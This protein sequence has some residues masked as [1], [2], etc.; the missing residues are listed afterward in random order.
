MKFDELLGVYVQM[1]FFRQNDLFFSY[2]SDSGLYFT[3]MHI[4][5]LGYIHREC[6][7]KLEKLCVR[8]K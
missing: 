6:D 8:N 7:S 3:W 2:G 5:V 1:Y 4:L